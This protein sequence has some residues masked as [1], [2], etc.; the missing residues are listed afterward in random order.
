MGTIQ[1]EIKV[2]I[3]PIETNTGFLSPFNPQQQNY[4]QQGYITSPIVFGMPP[5]L[6]LDAKS[7]VM[8][9]PAQQYQVTNS[10]ASILTTTSLSGASSTHHS[11]S[12]I[13]STSNYRNGATKYNSG[14]RIAASDS[15]AGGVGSNHA[16]QQIRRTRRG[17][18]SKTRMSKRTVE[19]NLHKSCP[20]CC[21][22][23]KNCK[24]ANIKNRPDPQPY[25]K[26]VPPRMLRKQATNQS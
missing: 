3:Q 9:Q 1:I 13:K 6:N 10:G 22:L 4:Q 12:S 20:S 15:F 11:R 18:V 24:C 17:H 8:I 14:N 26:F 21:K 16:H 5:P 7:S 2:I 25:C 23:W 19:V